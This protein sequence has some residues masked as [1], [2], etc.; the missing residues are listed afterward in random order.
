MALI[1]TMSRGKALTDKEKGKIEA[2]RQEK[3]GIRE[4]ARRLGR[5]HHVVLNY[6]RNP[7]G[8]GQIAKKTRRSKL[9]GRDKRRIVRIA[10]NSAKSLMQIKQELNLSVSRETVRQVLVKSPFIKRAK[11]AKAPNL[12]PSHIEK[13]L[14]FAR[15]NMNRQWDTVSYQSDS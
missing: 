14:N 11:K 4:I 13:R 1:I 2:F 3:V 12:T 8:Y 15:N 9:S 10:S 7:E 6:L 5:S